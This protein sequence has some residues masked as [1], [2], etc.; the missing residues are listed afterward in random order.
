METL[1]VVTMNYVTEVVL[2]YNVLRK[3]CETLYV[4]TKCKSMLNYQNNGG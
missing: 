1:L 3:Y 2:S 4:C